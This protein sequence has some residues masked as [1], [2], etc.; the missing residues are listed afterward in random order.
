LSTQSGYNDF[1]K[2][3]STSTKF[4]CIVKCLLITCIITH[5]SGFPLILKAGGT[6][7]RWVVNLGVYYNFLGWIMRCRG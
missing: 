2:V 4:M 1:E 7:T 3:A 5:S 6:C